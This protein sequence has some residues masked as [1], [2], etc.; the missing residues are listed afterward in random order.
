MSAL[1]LAVQ[2]AHVLG[3]ARGHAHP[4]DDP[5][6][7]L[8]LSAQVLIETGWDKHGSECECERCEAVLG[9]YH[10]A[11]AQIAWDGDTPP[12][13]VARVQTLRLLERVLAEHEPVGLWRCSCGWK[14]RGTITNALEHRTFRLY[15]ALLGRT[16]PTS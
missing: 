7:D 4:D 10:G 9:A 15:D 8:E 11:W 12:D 16:I 5:A 3:L 2:R 14:G 6:D 13:R 1:T